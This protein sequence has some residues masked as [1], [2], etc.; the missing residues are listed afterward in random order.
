MTGA[1]FR[2][3][4]ATLLLVLAPA[5]AI[6]G[7]PSAQHGSHIIRAM[8]QS[9]MEKRPPL[10]G[11]LPSLPARPTRPLPD[12]VNASPFHNRL[13]TETS[14]SRAASFAA[15]I[16]D[17]TLSLATVRSKA[18]RIDGLSNFAHPRFA[19]MEADLGLETQLGAHETLGLSGTWALER[20]RPSIKARWAS[21]R[22]KT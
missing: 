19:N 8:Q 17:F 6:A 22:W 11:F 1:S 21:R 15:D 20:R 12:A 2:A 3:S 5:A 10:A 16:G 13:T 4:G 9:S 18:V 14:K 7:A